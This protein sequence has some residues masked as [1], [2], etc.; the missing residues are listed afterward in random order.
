MRPPASALPPEREGVIKFELEFSHALPQ[1]LESIAELNAWRQLLFRLGLTGRDPARYGGLAYGNVS[2]RGGGRRFIISGTQTGAKPCL[3]AADYCLVLDF[4]LGNN[5]LQAEG[6]V[7]P[8]SEA[9]THG[10][11]YDAVPQAGCVI[12]V[13]SPEIW[14]KARQLGIC[15]TDASIAYGTPEMGWA[16]GA[17]AASSS[18][19]IIAMGGHED[20]VLAF[21][22][23]VGQAAVRL[24]QCLAQALELEQRATVTSGK[25]DCHSL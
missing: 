23:H 5:R 20:G 7:E 22:E 8:S 19:G 1:A 15:L 16:V 6:P 25:A 17:A 3:D 9:L 24:L 14:Q 2:R 13:H 12:H 18:T 21:A 10:A 4:D 11:V